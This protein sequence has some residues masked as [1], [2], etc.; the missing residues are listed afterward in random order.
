MMNARSAQDLL[1][2]VLSPKGQTEVTNYRTVKVPSDTEIPVF[3]K[4]EFT[5]F[6]KSMFETAYQRE[7]RQVAFMEYAWDMGSCDPCAAEPLSREELKQA[8]V[9]WLDQPSDEPVPMAPNLRRPPLPVNSSVFITRLHVRY[10]RDKFPEDLMFQETGNQE[11]FQGRYILRHAFTGEMKC[12]AGR[13]YRRA[14]PRRFE[15]EAQT[16]ARLTGWNIQEIRN[17]LP[18]LQADGRSLWERLWASLR[19]E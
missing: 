17:K 4:N 7:N 15:Q 12:S 18:K 16:L 1:I 9:F 10:T 8:G 13:E 5:D 11:L 2:Y 19:G 6:Y 14:L 3:V